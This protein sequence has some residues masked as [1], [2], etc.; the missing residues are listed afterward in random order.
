MKNLTRPL[1]YLLLLL[2]LALLAGCAETP[3]TPTDIPPRPARDSI[4]SFSLSGRAIISRSGQANTVRILWEHSPAADNIGFA[5]Q[6]QG[7]I[8]ELR[9][10]AGGARWTTAAGD[11]YDARNADVLIARLTKEPVPIAALALWVTGR[12]TPE[13]TDAQRDDKGRLISAADHGWVIKVISYETDLPNAMPSV[14]EVQS[15][16]VQIRIAFEEY[17]V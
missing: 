11:Y 9:R 7:M 13:A 5:T 4:S 3:K 1:R 8:A 2:G 17:I 10:D 12:V 6:L 14:I 16:T 15:P